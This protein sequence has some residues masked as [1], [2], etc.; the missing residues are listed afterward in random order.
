[1]FVGNVSIRVT[2]GPD[3][4]RTATALIVGVA[5]LHTRLEPP[6]EGLCGPL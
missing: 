5:N 3:A 4:E 2:L 1:M 6:Q